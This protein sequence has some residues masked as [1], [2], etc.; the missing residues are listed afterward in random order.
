MIHDIAEF[1]RV[2]KTLKIHEVL[3]G[4]QNNGNNW[5]NILA[6]SGMK[7]NIHA[8]QSGLYTLTFL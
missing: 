8:F 5:E 3:I 4:E 6:L 2:K 7:Y 1:M